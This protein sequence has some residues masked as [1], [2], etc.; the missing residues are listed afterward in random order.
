[1]KKLFVFLAL[2]VMITVL[3]GCSVTTKMVTRERVDQDL[4]SSAGNQGYLKGDRACRR[5]KKT[6]KDLYRSPG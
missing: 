2:A 6:H 3:T 5:R 1:M 4:S